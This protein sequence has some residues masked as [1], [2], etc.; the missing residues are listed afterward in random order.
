MTADPPGPSKKDFDARL[1]AAQARRA[2]PDGGT[3][4]G[5]RG[6]GLGFAFRISTELVAGVVLGVAIGLG[7][8]YWLDSRPWFMILFFFLG[9]GAGMLNV[10]RTVTGIG[11]AIGY[12]KLDR[13]PKAGAEGQGPAPKT[14]GGPD[15]SG[16]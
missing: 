10:Y 11:H 2:G 16:K 3:G 7:L 15:E 14:G 5:A 4:P 12:E 13:T 8:D 1:R 6:S 9:A